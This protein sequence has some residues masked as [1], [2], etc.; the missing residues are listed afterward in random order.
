MLLLSTMRAKQLLTL[1]LSFLCAST[2]AWATETTNVTLLE[3]NAQLQYQEAVR[4]DQVLSDA[5]KQTA[6]QK[7]TNTFDEGYRLFDTNKQEITDELYNSVVLRLKK[8]AADDDYS[9]A[10]EQLLQQIQ[11]YQYAYRIVTSLDIDKV[12]LD[13]SRNPK[14]PGDYELSLSERPSVVYLAGLAAPKPVTF[15][16][17]YDVANYLEQG[18]LIHQASQSFAWVIAPNGTTSKVGIAY[19]NNQHS[20]VIPGSIIFVGFDSSSSE[21]ADLEQDIISL[22]TMVKR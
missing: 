9:T 15:S 20:H 19:W 11:S 6:I 12:R 3:H 14:M 5:L 21:L 16:S 18:K 7:Q 2:H 8:L 13:L 4:L 22:L 1:T 10:A 17:F